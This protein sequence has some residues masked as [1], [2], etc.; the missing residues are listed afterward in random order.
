MIE[1][2]YW[3]GD[4]WPSAL[5]MLIVSAI[6]WALGHRDGVRDERRRFNQPWCHVGFEHT[7]GGQKVC[8]AM[9]DLNDLIWERKRLVSIRRI[10]R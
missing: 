3:L 6:F 2:I 10:S 4:Q 5:V 9:L 8:K 7:K 1:R